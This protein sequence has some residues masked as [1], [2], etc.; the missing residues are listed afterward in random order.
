MIRIFAPSEDV[1]EPDAGARPSTPRA[2]PRPAVK[3]YKGPER[4][5]GPTDIQAG[6]TLSRDV[7]TSN[8]ALYLG[9]GTTLTER[10]IGVLESL[11][12]TGKLT[13]KIWVAL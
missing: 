12:E 3:K 2:A 7:H 5:L 10:H 8:G 1:T 9:A 13:N 11:Y 4:A 6:L